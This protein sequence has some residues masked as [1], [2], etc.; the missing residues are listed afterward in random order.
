MKRLG[1]AVVCLSLVLLAGCEE[2][3]RSYAGGQDLDQELV[4]TL[5]N[6]GVEA[7]IIREHTLYPYHFVSDGK[8]LNELGERDF[9]VLAEH[10]QQYDGTLNVR[11]GET[12][13]DLYEAR[14]AYILQKLNEAGIETGRISVKDGM[15]GGSGMPSERVVD[16]MSQPLEISGSGGAG[17]GGSGSR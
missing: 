5:N 10:L 8:A 1:V 11:R 2:G 9:S 7:A 14:V 3:Q 4:K 17:Y 6:A 13:A 12:R 15:P 16:V